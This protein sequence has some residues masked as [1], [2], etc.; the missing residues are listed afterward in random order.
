MATA[1]KKAMAMAAKIDGDSNK[2]GKGGKR[3]GNSN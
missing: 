2:E 1:M 3:F